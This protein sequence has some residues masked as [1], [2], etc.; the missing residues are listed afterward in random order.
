MAQSSGEQAPAEGRD[1]AGHGARKP[2]RLGEETA[3]PAIRRKRPDIV[4]RREAVVANRDRERRKW[5][6]ERA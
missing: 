4:S 5:E 3:S 6:G 2:E 1:R